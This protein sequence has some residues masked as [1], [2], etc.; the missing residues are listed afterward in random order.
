MARGRKTGSPKTGGRK[1]GTRNRSTEYVAEV[2]D[3]LNCEPIEGM[4]RIAMRDI[5]CSTCGG[6]GRV[7]SRD[8]RKKE[9]CPG[10][11]GSG[12]EPIPI[13]LAAKMLS[14][15]AS[16]R[17]PKLKAVEHRAS[18]EKGNTVSLVELLTVYREATTK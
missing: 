17:Y 12:K 11:A 15:L 6:A 8:L 10:C 5:P 1:K 13:G 7:P 3:R 9:A 16:Y 14:E 18:D 4:A 2:L